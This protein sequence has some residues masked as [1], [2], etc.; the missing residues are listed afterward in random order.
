MK[1]MLMVLGLAVGLAVPV[2]AGSMMA[3]GPASAASYALLHRTNWFSATPKAGAISCQ[4]KT[5]TLDPLPTGYRY[6]WNQ[7]FPKQDALGPGTE[8]Q[9][10]ELTF[11]GKFYWTVCMQSLKGTKGINT[12]YY[13]Y[14]E[15]STLTRVSSACENQG[16]CTTWELIPHKIHM[17]D[18][19]NA[20][21]GS[22]IHRLTVGWCSY[23]GVC[24]DRTKVVKW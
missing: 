17:V 20:N 4:H 10:Y 5:I 24:S 21:W 18:S 14:E 2:V 7:F 15:W 9:A 3:A 1:R 23:P 8:V 22:Q 6:A 19:G 11:H 16:N 12:T 13:P